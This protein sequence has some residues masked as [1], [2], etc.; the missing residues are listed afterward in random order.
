MK[1]LP[2]TLEHQAR[3]EH[4][5]LRKERVMGQ[6]TGDMI[7]TN[8][9]EVFSTDEKV[10]PVSYRAQMIVS[11]HALLVALRVNRNLMLVKNFVKPSVLNLEYAWAL[12]NREDKE[13]VISVAADVA[14]ECL[15]E[16]YVSLEE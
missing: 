7:C 8:C 6:Q 16:G 10:V 1:F 5:Q 12:I 13:F 3:C 14:E 4:S 9:G 15:S 2:G 11:S